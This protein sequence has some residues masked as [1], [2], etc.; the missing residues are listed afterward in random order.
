MKNTETQIIEYACPRPV[1]RETTPLEKLLN[2]NNFTKTDDFDK[3]S[4]IVDG[5]YSRKYD[6]N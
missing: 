4:E 1:Y 2:F 3:M 6:F 5:K